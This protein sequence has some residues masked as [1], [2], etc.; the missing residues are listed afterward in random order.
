[1]GGVF[2]ELEV[3]LLCDV[4][5]SDPVGALAE[6]VDGEN[7]FDRRALRTIE[8]CFD[9]YRVEV[10][11]GGFDVGEKRCGPGA[12]DG[13]RGGEEA[14]GGGDD[15]VTGA[16]FGGCQ[17]EPES[18]CARGATDGVGHA[19]PLRGGF[20]KGGNRLAQNK[21]LRDQDLIE[22]VE[23]FLME[24]LVLAFEVHHG[25][26]LGGCGGVFRLIR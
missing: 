9:G 5:V 2:N 19:Q 3:V 23:K 16:N 24:G 4:V 6:E 1:M 20:F 10:E 21:L 13:A 15:G 26:R 17:C 8:N 22:G 25:H 14:E 7:G 12:E 11:G 18:V